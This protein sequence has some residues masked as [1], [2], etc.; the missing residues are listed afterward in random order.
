M[1]RLEGP[2]YVQSRIEL[3]SEARKAATL[4]LYILIKSTLGFFQR[5]GGMQD[6]KL[7]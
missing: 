4:F 3:R 2:S 5:D 7:L 6:I 1:L